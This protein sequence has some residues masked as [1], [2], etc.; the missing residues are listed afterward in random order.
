MK[1]KFGGLNISLFEIRATRFDGYGITVF[2]IK[3]N[4]I[5]RVTMSYHRSLLHFN[6][7]KDTSQKGMEF[8]IMFGA[9][10]CKAFRIF[11]WIVKPK[12]DICHDCGNYCETKEFY[13][14]DIPYCSKVC[15][16]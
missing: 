8:R 7:Y 13:D 9:L 11:D 16:W 2:N 14:K 3:Y 15:Q 1:T 12:K 6:F 5:E 10:F 4:I